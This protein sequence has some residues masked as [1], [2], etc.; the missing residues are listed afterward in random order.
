MEG[1]AAL[2]TIHRISTK[3]EPRLEVLMSWWGMNG[4]GVLNGS[5]EKWSMEKKLRGIAE[6]G[7]D[8]IGCW[9]NTIFHTA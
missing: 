2:S 7:Y 1:L 5:G 8:G 6:A 3:R 4:L 9:I